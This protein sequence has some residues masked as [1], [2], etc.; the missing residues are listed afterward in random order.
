MPASSSEEKLLSEIVESLRALRV[1]VGDIK[2]RVERIESHSEKI[3][4]ESTEIYNHVGFIQGIYEKIKS[5]LFRI[6]S[7]ASGSHLS[8]PERTDEGRITVV[9]VKDHDD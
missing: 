6:M 1:E 5:P 8:A 3:S 9:C 2:S 4:G 7:F